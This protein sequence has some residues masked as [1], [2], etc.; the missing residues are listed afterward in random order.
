MVFPPSVYTHPALPESEIIPAPRKP[1][2]REPQK[3]LRSSSRYST[4]RD[5]LSRSHYLLSKKLSLTSPALISYFYEAIHGINAW[6]VPNAYF[7]ISDLLAIHNHCSLCLF[8]SLSPFCLS[9]SH[10]TLSLVL[11]LFLLFSPL[12]LALSLA[13]SLLS[14][15][16]FLSAAFLSIQISP[17]RIKLSGLFEISHLLLHTN[18]LYGDKGSNNLEA[19]GPSTT[20]EPLL[21][22]D[23]E[24]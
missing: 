12:S 24:L 23:R 17:W 4:L 1:G 13:Q 9:V 15:S 22:R 6:S 3:S 8:P 5:P 18:K 20:R 14:R 19:A 11:S 7:L 16:F 21:D 2:G 10:P